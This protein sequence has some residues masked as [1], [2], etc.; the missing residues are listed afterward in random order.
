MMKVRANKQILNLPIDLSLPVNTFWDLGV[1]DNMTVWFHQFANNQHRF[2]NYYEN[3]NEGIQ[4]YVTYMK[5]F[6]DKHGFV[7]GT[8]Y[9]PHDLAV[10]NLGA[11]IKTRKEIFKQLGVDINI[12][13]RTPAKQD[14]IQN[15]RTILPNC[16]F[17]EKR[18]STGISYLDNYT[19]E[20]DK[21]LAVWKNEPRHDMASHC[22][23]AFLCF[24]DGWG[25]NDPV[26]IEDFEF[27]SEW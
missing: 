19:K 23:D 26:I 3:S 7:W 11:N 9:G 10:R 27:T 14:S 13:P 15:A 6:Q 24:A 16:W 21:R 12:V 22:A 1:S 4:H 2:V 17:D 5:E 25:L 20:W 18:C 8:H